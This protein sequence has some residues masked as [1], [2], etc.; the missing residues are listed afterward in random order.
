MR[1]RSELRQLERVMSMMR[2]MPPNVTAGLARSRVR[3]YR[4]SPAPPASRTPRVS[5]M[6]MNHPRETVDGSTGRNVAVALCAGTRSRLVEATQ[7]RFP[8]SRFLASFCF[9]GVNECN[10]DV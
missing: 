6:D 4:R 5:F 3:G 8:R 1:R 10:G 7:A 2:Y 9:A